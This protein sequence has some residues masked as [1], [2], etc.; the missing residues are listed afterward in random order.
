MEQLL[1]GVRNREVRERHADSMYRAFTA[2]T[3]VFSFSDAVKKHVTV[4]KCVELLRCFISPEWSNR[5]LSKATFSGTS[6]AFFGVFVC[7]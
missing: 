1:T 4:R 6:D 3:I 7:F 5:D 2:W